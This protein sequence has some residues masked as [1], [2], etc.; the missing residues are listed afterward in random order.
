MDGAGGACHGAGPEAQG[1]HP[2]PAYLNLVLVIPAAAVAAEGTAWG[3][4]IV[5]LGSSPQLCKVRLRG[6]ELQ[7]GACPTLP[8]RRVCIYLPSGTGSWGPEHSLGS[9]RQQ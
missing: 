6:A 3:T 8:W 2:A 9:H 7:A 5:T 4:G 1:S